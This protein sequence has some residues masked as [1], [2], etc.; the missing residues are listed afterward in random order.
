MHAVRRSDQRWTDRLDAFLLVPL[1]MAWM[2]FV[3]RPIRIYG[4]A[5]C[6]RQGWGTR[7]GKAETLS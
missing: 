1:A 4:M 5:T 3:L 7:Q 2:T 6:L